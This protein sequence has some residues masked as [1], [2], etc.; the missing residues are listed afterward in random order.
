VGQKEFFEAHG[1]LPSE[2]EKNALINPFEQGLY[3]GQL[4]EEIS[5]EKSDSEDD[6]WIT[7][8]LRGPD[9][10]ISSFL[11]PPIVA[12]SQKP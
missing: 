3:K 5:I 4:I 1:F 6:D 9:P 2:I 7:F 11:V 8:K 12:K 10:A